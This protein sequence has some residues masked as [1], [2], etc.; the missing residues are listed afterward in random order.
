MANHAKGVHPVESPALRIL[1]RA[2]A[3]LTSAAMGLA[4]LA[5]LM[6]LAL[7][8]WAVVMRYAFNAAPTWVDDLVG[9]NLVAIVML[10]AAQT[11]RHG[12]HIGVDLL[13][14]NLSA[15]GRRWAAGWAALATGVI[16]LVLVLNGT[17][18]ALLARSLGLLTE[19][20]LEW[21]TWRLMLLMPVGGAL[22]LLAA[23]E[24][25]WRAMAGL[26][27]AGAHT[28]VDDLKINPQAPR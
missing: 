26:P 28:S 6:S 15:R 2:V 24:Q 3:L 1:G 14:G 27:L 11:L 25:L 8:G 10:A 12:E 17:G 23:I 18:T 5:L 4:A 21:P 13:T 9:F 19:G 22:L 20:A 7:I 16:A